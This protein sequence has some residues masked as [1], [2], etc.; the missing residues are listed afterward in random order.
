MNGLLV[1][2]CFLK[3]FALR[4]A[5]IH[6]MYVLVLGISGSSYTLPYSRLHL[7]V[8]RAKKSQ[9]STFSSGTDGGMKTETVVGQKNFLERSKDFCDLSR[10]KRQENTPNL[11]LD[12][13]Q[14]SFLFRTR[15]PAP[16]TTDC[17]LYSSASFVGDDVLFMSKCIRAQGWRLEIR[18][19]CVVQK[20][21]EV[22]CDRRVL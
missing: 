7:V 22:K 15:F 6:I 21:G 16:H 8:H 9:Y 19:G 11:L 10:Y 17:R 12:A 1:P 20:I 2:L 4:L 3:L 5:A 18:G 14:V 13:F